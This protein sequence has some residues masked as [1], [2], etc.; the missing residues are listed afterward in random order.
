VKKIITT[1]DIISMQNAAKKI[2]LPDNVVEYLTK[3]VASTRTDIHVVMGASPRADIAFMA[4]AKARAL[5][6]GRNT[7]TIDDIKFLAKPVLSHRISVRS[8]GGIGV[9]GI[10]DGIVATLK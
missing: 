5:I 7:A 4:A 3:I 6:Y 1:E 8:T 9:K 2:T 10:I